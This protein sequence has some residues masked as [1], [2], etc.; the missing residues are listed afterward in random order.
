M[1]IITILHF[2]LNVALS[3]TVQF[4]AGWLLIVFHNKTIS[5]IKWFFFSFSG[6][7]VIWSARWP[8]T[9]P[10]LWL[11][12]LS[13]VNCLEIEETLKNRKCKT[14]KSGRSWS[15]SHSYLRAREGFNFSKKSIPCIIHGPMKICNVNVNIWQRDDSA[16]FGNTENNGNARKRMISIIKLRIF[17]FRNINSHIICSKWKAT[18]RMIWEFWTP[19]YF[20]YFSSLHPQIHIID[21]NNN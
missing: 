7:T 14:F 16:D 4:E 15:I 12:R 21:N 17:C 10:Q 3:E 5:T 6:R 13:Q 18:T 1:Y 9:T 19:T 2:T 8:T 11:H 20:F